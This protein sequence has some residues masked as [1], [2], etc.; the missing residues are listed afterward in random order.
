MPA[1]LVGFTESDRKVKAVKMLRGAQLYASFK[2]I[3]EGL[4]SSKKLKEKCERGAPT[5]AKKNGA[6]GVSRGS[7]ERLTGAQSVARPPA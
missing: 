4:L 1:F 5:S 7:G 2:R 6:P 3:N